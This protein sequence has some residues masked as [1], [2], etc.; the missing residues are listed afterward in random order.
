[1][2]KYIFVVFL[3]SFFSFI[4]LI[5]VDCFDILCWLPENGKMVGEAK[6][7]SDLFTDAKRC[8]KICKEKY[9]KVCKA[10]PGTGDM[11]FPAVFLCVYDC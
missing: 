8:Q 3:I 10:E 11:Y 6:E 1:M 5:Y 4:N 2:N 7:C 9:N